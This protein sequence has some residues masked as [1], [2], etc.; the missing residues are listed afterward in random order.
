MSNLRAF[1]LGSVLF[2]TLFSLGANGDA[3]TADGSIVGWGSQTIVADPTQRFVSL[4]TGN[5]YLRENFYGLAL[6]TNGSITNWGCWGGPPNNCTAPAP[7]TDFVAIAAGGS[8]LGLKADGTIV[9]WGAGYWCNVPLPNSGFIAIAAGE[10]HNVGL[11]AGGSIVT[12]VCPGDYPEPYNGLWDSLRNV[13]LPN[14]GFMAIAAGSLHSLGL[15]ADGMIVAWGV[16][17]YGQCDVPTT[18]TGFTKIAAGRWHSLA[19]R[20]DGSVVAWGRNDYGQC[21]V[22]LPNSGFVAIAAG[23]WHSLGLKADGSVVAWG[24]NHDGQCDVPVPNAGFVAIAA[25]QSYSLAL[26][27]IRPTCAGCSG[28]N[29]CQDN[30]PYTQDLCVNGCC[31]HQAVPDWLQ[32]PHCFDPATGNVTTLGCAD[33]CQVASCTLGGNQGAAQCTARTA[34]PCDDK[35][36][37]TINDLCRAPPYPNCYGTDI[38][39]IACVT[40]A[41]CPEMANCV[42]GH[43]ACSLCNMLGDPDGDGVFGVCDNCPLVFNPGQEDRDGDGVGDACDN[44]PSLFD[45]DRPHQP[46]VDGDGVGDLCDNCPCAWNP[47]QEDTDHNRIGDACEEPVHPELN[48]QECDDGN[49]CTFGD[50]CHYG[51]CEGTD[52]NTIECI[53]PDWPPP[54]LCE[55]GGGQWP[56]VSGFCWCIC[57]GPTCGVDPDGDGLYSMSLDTSDPWRYRSCDNCPTVFNPGQEDLDGDGIGDACDNCPYVANF[58]QEDVDRDGI[59]EACQ[60]WASF[61]VT[62]GA[63]YDKARQLV[64]VTAKVRDNSTGMFITNG[65]VRWELQAPDPYDCFSIMQYNGQEWTAQCDYSSAPLP[66]GPYPVRV[67]AG[68]ATALVEL[69]VPGV[70]GQIRGATVDLSGHGI[71]GAKVRLYANPEYFATGSA[72]AIDEVVSQLQGDFTFENVELGM[73]VVTA[74]VTGLG[75]VWKQVLVQPG[76]VSDADRILLLM[77]APRTLAQLGTPMQTLYDQCA[78]TLENQ[79]YRMSDMTSQAADLFNGHED[80]L[81]F[82]GKVGKGVAQGAMDMG[83]GAITWLVKEASRGT[84]AKAT[85]A[86]IAGPVL[87]A[88]LFEVAEQGIRADVM[89]MIPPEF[90]ASGWRRISPNELKG[91]PE[92]ERA[93]GG[94]ADARADL[95][96]NW[97]TIT[98]DD[99]FDFDL[100][101]SL[102]EGS[103]RNMA[104]VSVGDPVWLPKPLPAD[105]ANWLEFPANWQIWILATASVEELGGGATVTS[106]I[107][108]LATDITFGAT[109]T[110]VGL[111]IVPVV[112]TIG[113]I[114]G[115]SSATLSLV[116][117]SARIRASYI[118]V[119]SAWHW[120]KDL[121]PISAEYISLKHFLENEARTPMYL[122]GSKRFAAE[123]QL[124]LHPDVGDEFLC[125]PAPGG[126]RSASLTVKNTGS[127]QAQFRTFFIASLDHEAPNS[128]VWEHIRTTLFGGGQ[129]ISV[130]ITTGGAYG[131]SGFLL[132]AGESRVLDI[133]FGVDN[134]DSADASSYRRLKV[135]VYAGPFLVGSA[136]KRFWLVPEGYASCGSNAKANRSGS[137]ISFLEGDDVQ[138]SHIGPPKW[139]LAKSTLLVDDRVSPD[140]PT[141][142]HDFHVAKDAVAVQF[143]LQNEGSDSIALQVC[144]DVGRCAGLQ[145]RTGGVKQE[146]P[147]SFSSFGPQRQ[148]VNI[149][150]AAGQSFHVQVALEGATATGRASPVKIWAIATPQRPA[151]LAVAPS[152]LSVTTYPG[153]EFIFSM[154]LAEAGGQVPLNYVVVTCSGLYDA[155]GTSR[156]GLVSPGIYKFA[157]MLAAS[158]RVIQFRG[159]A[160]V[161]AVPGHFSGV[162]TICTGNAGCKS[163]DVGVT[164]LQSGDFDADGVVGISDAGPLSACMLGADLEIGG[165]CRAFDFD[166]DH[167]V[168]LRDFSMFQNRFAGSKP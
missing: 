24:Y 29:D 155:T 70:V 73:Y 111:S 56:C 152:S 129:I 49:P 85:S 66:A 109:M 19:L 14:T 103:L 64:T 144:D 94:L 83:P 151:I 104:L 121:Y 147:A 158:S 2:S 128:D 21:D 141:L 97:N 106:N 119:L 156:M 95:M 78:S 125:P 77:G 92:T 96:R 81:E 27:S 118:Y 39:T 50:K 35:N 69:R 67:T 162:V 31:A 116:E 168:D 122:D 127:S 10:L 47:L 79:T 148:I 102:I 1:A 33:Q 37:C 52:V 72:P 114:A 139:I 117:L 115:F 99:H 51:R 145:S 7:N 108:I 68:N 54:T 137:R 82:A 140:F 22:P 113:V 34:E 138:D 101:R 164:L 142:S 153:D 90:E 48:G 75:K 87:E 150:D 41:D 61:S 86:L 16:N 133:L 98:V 130:P 3:V 36:L 80:V 166:G 6:G 25:G 12:W 38:N 105:G 44:C 84:F 143:E 17:D 159:V 58:Y 5:S 112:G 161:R 146:F 62:A 71:A 100:A 107:S 120:L 135:D 45:W 30:D 46:D 63:V 149:P 9:E 74:E 60:L 167:D 89:K 55:L 160:P 32:A 40:P 136:A 53:G 57:C 123:L 8:A 43:C 42:N 110:G 23:G 163:V 131:D 4:A 18:S 126:L 132:N 59:G 88:A 154:K 134:S 28:P 91:W 165:G 157:R 20:S 124:D 11:K 65:I 76:R 26:T 13:P 93:W 15:K